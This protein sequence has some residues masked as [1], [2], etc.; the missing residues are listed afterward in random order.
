MKEE[1]PAKPSDL[2]LDSWTVQVEAPEAFERGVWKRIASHAPEGT[3]GFLQWLE[4]FGEWITR[5]TVAAAVAS[6]VLLLA[7]AGGEVHSRIAKARTLDRLSEQ[8]LVS[9]D[10]LARSPQFHQHPIR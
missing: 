8:Y 1:G 7:V 3:R 2:P 4:P 6:G 5:P 10:P 9:I